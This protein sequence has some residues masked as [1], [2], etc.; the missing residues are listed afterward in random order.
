MYATPGDAPATMSW[1]EALAYAGNL[2]EHGFRDW[3]LPTKDEL[4]VLF[5]NSAAIGGFDDSSLYPGGWYWTSSEDS[6]SAAWRQR[7]S[8]GR[9]NILNKDKS[10]AV[11]CV[12]SPHSSERIQSL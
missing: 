10:A 12:R 3:R 8:D 2:N 6:A 5:K 11:R 4:D 9:Q 7:F 1:K